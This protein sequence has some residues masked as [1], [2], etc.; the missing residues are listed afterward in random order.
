MTFKEALSSV[1]SKYAT[2]EGR[3]RRS[4]Y[5]YF[6]LFTVIV[7]A[8]L[9][10]LVPVAQGSHF[11]WIFTGASGLFSLATLIPGLAVN[12]RRMH[13]IGKSGAWYFIILVPLVGS[14]LYLVWCCRDSQ[15]G[16]NMYGPNPKSTQLYQ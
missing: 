13:D 8:V 11:Q 1:F 7:N 3:A 16:D 14:I 4:E 12:W 5:W 10:M 6:I 2:F 9:N 15:P